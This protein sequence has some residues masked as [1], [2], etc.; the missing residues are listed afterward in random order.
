M[1]DNNLKISVT[2]SAHEEGRDEQ[3]DLTL[4]EI[5]SL[6]KLK[7]DDVLKEATRSNKQREYFDS[8]KVALEDYNPMISRQNTDVSMNSTVSECLSSSTSTGMSFKCL[9]AKSQPPATPQ[10]PVVTSPLKSPLVPRRRSQMLTSPKAQSR[11]EF[12][13]QSRGRINETIDMLQFFVLSEKASNLSKINRVA[14][15]K[16]DIKNSPTESLPISLTKSSFSNLVEEITSMNSLKSTPTLS[17]R[18]DVT[19]SPFVPFFEKKNLEQEPVI[20][21]LLSRS[22]FSAAEKHIQ[23]VEKRL[24]SDVGLIAKYTTFDEETIYKIFDLFCSQTSKTA[25]EVMLFD[26][27]CDTLDYYATSALAIRIFE[28]FDVHRIGALNFIQFALGLSILTGNSLIL[29]L[30]RFVFDI[31]DVDKDGKISFLEL[32]AL[33]ENTLAEKRITFTSDEVVKYCNNT[34]SSLKLAHFSSIDYE[35]FLLLV[36]M[37]DVVL[38]PFQLSLPNILKNINSELPAIE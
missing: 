3:P 37:T 20:D 30:S 22:S 36:E 7:S 8:T 15:S 10:S 6:K 35:G 27:F 28:I 23:I 24:A 32:K 14:K 26:E 17:K 34:L 16:Y 11:D 38:T 21:D 33:V 9:V 1:S 18:N 4:F 13:D 29:T 31:Y 2:P 25:G 19:L 5:F 12:I